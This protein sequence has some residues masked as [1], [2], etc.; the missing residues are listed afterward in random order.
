MKEELR[1]KMSLPE[2]EDLIANLKELIIR[3]LRLEDVSPRG[4][5]CC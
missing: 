5:R 1:L 3:T 4:H 2:R